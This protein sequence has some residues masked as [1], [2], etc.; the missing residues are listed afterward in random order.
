MANARKIECV[1]CESVATPAIPIEKLPAGEEEWKK[2]L[3][4]E[5]FFI[6]RQGGTERAYTGEY[7]HHKGDGTYACAGCGQPLYDSKTKYDSCGWP[8]FWDALPG[9]VATR[10]DG[11]SP[12]AICSRCRGHLGHVFDD[13]PEPTG[14]RH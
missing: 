2:K 7:L 11:G 1:G 13:G 12:E 6:L 3:S 4:P 8:S 9:A 10:D 14:K 5:R